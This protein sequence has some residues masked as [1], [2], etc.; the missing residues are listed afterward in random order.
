MWYVLIHSLIQYLF[1]EHLLCAIY[2]FT[3]QENSVINPTK[4]STFLELI[5]PTIKNN[6]HKAF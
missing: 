1:T 6:G 5:Y 3:S 2:Y 4:F